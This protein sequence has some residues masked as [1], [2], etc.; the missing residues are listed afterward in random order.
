MLDCFAKLGLAAVLSLAALPLAA[1]DDGKV[2]R[3]RYLVEEV[4]RCQ[5]CHSPKLE[6]GEF[7]RS[8][9]LKGA[10]LEVQPVQP[11][12]GWHKTAPDLTAASRLFQ[13]WGAE[14]L[15]KYFVTG[16]N[17]QG[18]PADRP[19][20]TYKLKQDDAEAIVEFLKSLK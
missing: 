10:V 8:R 13:R 9:W 4:G 1:A 12:Q 16:L 14:N 15:V 18:K 19:M 17:P 20:P 6:T 5:E 2:E 11:I 7:D 3:G